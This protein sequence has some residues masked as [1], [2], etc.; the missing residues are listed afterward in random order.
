VRPLRICAAGRQRVRADAE[1]RHAKVLDPVVGRSAR[2]PSRMVEE[3]HPAT[4]PAWALRPAA[5]P[6]TPCPVPTYGF[7]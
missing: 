4:V 2:V 1:V 7:D 3:V 5:S 6:I